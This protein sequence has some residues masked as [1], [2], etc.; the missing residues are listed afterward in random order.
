ML[1][2]C[3]RNELHRAIKV[4]I[5]IANGVLH[6][7]AKRTLAFCHTQTGMAWYFSE[8]LHLYWY[9]YAYLSR[10]RF[11]RRVQQFSTS[12]TL[13]RANYGG[14][15]FD[16]RKFTKTIDRPTSIL[17]LTRRSLSNRTHT[18]PKYVHV[19]I[20]GIDF[21]NLIW[22]KKLYRELLLK[23]DTESRKGQK[24]TKCE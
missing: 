10:R 23:K 17:H 12:L 2:C 19:G 8:F 7:H 16:Y 24:V 3:V 14:V 15:N 21:V 11:Y 4:G 6:I 18:R 9:H 1:A 13:T 20:S 22:K 5:N